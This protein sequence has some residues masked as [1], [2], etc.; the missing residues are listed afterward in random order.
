MQVH[1]SSSELEAGL[2]TSSSPPALLH[3]LLR[4]AVLAPSRHNTQ[5]WIFD[6]AGDEVAVHADPS[7]ALPAADPDG[8]QQ[9]MACG[10]AIVNL[11]IAA[12]HHGRATS[13]ESCP[14]VHDD[15]LL[16]RVRLEERC[17][18]TEVGE[19]LFQ[20]I[21]RRRTNR[22]PLDGR[23][24]PEGLVT[25]LLRAARREGVFLG[26]VEPHQRAEVAELVA[27]ADRRHWADPRFRAELAAW[28]RPNTSARRDG[29]FGWS[30]GMGDAASMLEPL[31]VRMAGRGLEEAERD[32]RRALATPALLVLST[33]DDGP[34]AWLAAGEALQRVLLRA[35][36]AGLSASHF[37]Q[38][39][40]HPDL[41]LRLAAA[42]G[43]T[44]KPQA[45]FRLG[46][47]LEVR[48]PPRRPIDEVVRGY[49]PEG[50]PPA[51]LVL[52]GSL[53]V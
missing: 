39:I 43:A 37:S 4:W 21:P 12:A 35:A 38:P 8:R 33:P 1:P 6:I 20:A 14:G 18:T 41:R 31:R 9:V 30:Q 46:Y 24:P 22:L 23:E 5:P 48:G 42:S 36:A 40:E 49:A 2:A 29:L 25:A 47:G 52:R 26:P 45:L 51:A 7:R 50:H 3:D 15:G 27:E 28:T 34:A 44:G 19:A 10:A 53:P 13:V 17:A 11:R 32:R 16:A